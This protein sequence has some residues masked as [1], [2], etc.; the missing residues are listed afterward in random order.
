MEVHP[1]SWLGIAAGHPHPSDVVALRWG[2]L[3]ISWIWAALS[4]RG[5]P[6]ASFLAALAFGTAAVGFWVL[7]LGRPYGLLIDPDATRRAAEAAVVAETRDASLDFIVAGVPPTGLHV[8]LALLGLDPV[9]LLL[10]PTLSPLLAFLA[11]A[12]LVGLLA[13]RGRSHL[14]ASLWLAFPSSA[15]ELV[16]GHGFLSA[17][18]RRPEGFLSVAPIVAVLL[19]LGRVRRNVWLAVSAG[20]VV[21]GCWAI[22]VPSAGAAGQGVFAALLPLTL[23]Q[24]PFFFLGAWGLWRHWDSTAGMLMVA[25]SLVVVAASTLPLALDPWC[26]QTLYRLG[27]LVAACGPIQALERGLGTRLQGF[28]PLARVGASRLGRALL[29]A[30]AVPAS[31]LAWWNPIQLDGRVAERSVEPLPG[32]LLQA[33]DW[34]RRNTDRHKTFVASPEYAPAVAALAGR[35][36]LRAPSLAQPPDNVRRRAQKAA[37]E[38]R[39]DPALSRFGVGYLLIGPGDAEKWGLAEPEQRR[40]LRVLFRGQGGHFAVYAL[41]AR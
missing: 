33:M 18:W 20:V 9:L 4:L 28:A 29:L 6:L 36:V 26:G 21:A 23:G 38:G 1:G 32:T 41:G 8:R 2:L 3:V 19:L 31:A 34:I 17:P 12:I 40:G 39:F 13:P 16:W 35:Q 5:R 11:V 15:I 10:L 27:L 30:L 14:A 25:G 22:L 7:A 24:G 37:L